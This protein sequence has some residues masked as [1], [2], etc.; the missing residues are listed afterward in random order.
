[1]NWGSNSKY[2]SH[3]AA[4]L[5]LYF[6][7]YND[8]GT[9]GLLEAYYE[10][11][12]GKYVA[13]RRLDTVAQA[14]P[15]LRARFASYQAFADS[16]ID[17]I[18]GERAAQSR[19]VE[20]N[21]LESIVLLNRGNRFE[22]RL[23]PPEAQFAPAFAVVAADFDGDGNEDIFLSQNFFATEPETSRCDAG[24]GLWLKGDGHG[25]LLPMSG[26]ESGITI[27]GEQRGAAV[28]DFDGD[29]RVDLVV[30]QNAAE[31]RLFKNVQGK[32]GLRVR[33]K[34]PPG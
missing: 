17:E 12:M 7:D 27:Y 19:F 33:L 9:L 32:P 2:Q 1:G 25:G 6:G 20:A 3:R 29:G 4:P 10:P 23:M 18:L 21:W 13:E 16:G 22:P 24:R 11:A 28:A 34:G 14:M 31:T 8:D 30:T 26:V 5:R 15:F